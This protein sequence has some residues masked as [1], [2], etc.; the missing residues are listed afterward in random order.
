MAGKECRYCSEEISEKSKVCRYCG[1]DQRI[2]ITRIKDVASIATLAMIGIAT[3]QVII[4]YGQFQELKSKRIE[5]QQVF[6]EAK[7]V[8]RN[9]ST[10]SNNAI[11]KANHVFSNASGI[12]NKAI[13]NAQTVLVKAEKSAKSANI[14]TEKA[15]KEM[16]NTI[17]MVNKQLKAS[18]EHVSKTEK[19]LIEKINLLDPLK[20]P[21]Y[22]V[23][24]TVE[25]MTPST[26][27]RNIHLEDE[28]AYLL[29]VDKKDEILVSLSAGDSHLISQDNNKYL[30][31]WSMLR[32][33]ETSPLIGKPV[34]FL[35]QTEY[36]AIRFNHMNDNER[37]IGGR[38][39]VIINNAIQLNFKIS[40]QNITDKLKLIV[41]QD[42]KSSL[43]VLK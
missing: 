19:E 39:V 6:D 9:A 4:N 16:K 43:S 40:E 34:S 29:L 38:V 33:P 7:R 2:I 5:A 12:S 10:K 35:K 26:G 8:F 14:I 30:L 18:N 27:R 24:A 17:G 15:E 28:G 13:M 21:I 36:L 31:Y 22:A 20:Q 11:V 3:V 32:L 1:R 23:S 42:L 41:V 37:V 25:A